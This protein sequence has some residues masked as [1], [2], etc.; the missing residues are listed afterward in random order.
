MGRRATQSAPTQTLK[1][2]LWRS[3]PLRAPGT[4]G[5]LLF[6]TSFRL[7]FLESY[8]CFLVDFYT[9]SWPASYYDLMPFGMHHFYDADTG[10]KDQHSLLR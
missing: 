7:S 9:L 1:F 3:A 5:L 2:G 6:P 4:P 8:L 10:N